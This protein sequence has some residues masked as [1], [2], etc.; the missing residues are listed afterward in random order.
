MAALIKPIRVRLGLL[1]LDAPLMVGVSLLA[2]GLAHAG[3]VP[4]WGGALLLLLLIG[5]TTVAITLARKEVDADVV[6]EFDSGVPLEARAVYIELFCILAGLGLLFLG[7]AVFIRSTLDIARSLGV[8]EAVIGLTVVAAGTSVPELATSL[9]AAARGQSD[10][11]IGNVIGSNIFNILGILGL[12]ST[13][14][15][16]S[17]PGVAPLDLWVMVG[18]AVALLPLLWTGRRLQRLEGGL[19]LAGY[20]G[21][22]WLLWPGG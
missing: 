1:R 5:Y 21:Y 14:Q 17:A 19:L 2:A 7:S 9:V 10:I 13:V 11:A 18:F 3:A 4:R 12:A 15:P 8:G 22:L 20:A 16:F 6:R